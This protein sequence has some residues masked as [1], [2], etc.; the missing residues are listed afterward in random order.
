MSRNLL[1]ILLLVL[2]GC[3]D[4]ALPPPPSSHGTTKETITTRIIVLQPGGKEREE[5]KELN[6]SLLVGEYT[7][8]DGY[9][10]HHILL[11]KDGN[12]TCEVE[13]CRGTYGTA[14]GVW[15]VEKQGVKLVDKKSAGQLKNRPPEI[16]LILCSTEKYFLVPDEHRAECIAEGLGSNYCFEKQPKLRSDG[17]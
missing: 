8:G 5:D 6:P 2:T 3:V 4:S 11:K 9:V 1:M 17:R 12:F 16:L 15:S 14:S 7:R 10:R 13:G